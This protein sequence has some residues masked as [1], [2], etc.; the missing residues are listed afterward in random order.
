MGAILSQS[1]IRPWLT[2]IHVK[3]HAKKKKKNVGND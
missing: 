3:A 1:H 2:T